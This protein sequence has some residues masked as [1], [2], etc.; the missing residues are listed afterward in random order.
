[1]VFVPPADSGDVS[2]VYPGLRRLSLSGEVSTLTQH[3]HLARSLA[4]RLPGLKALSLEPDSDVG[5]RGLSCDQLAELSRLPALA[6][7]AVP[8]DLADC[9]M[10]MPR[11]VFVLGEFPSLRYGVNWY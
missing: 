1:M 4:A 9:V 5:V 2:A 3:P 8:M 10:N 7:L 11:I 6:R